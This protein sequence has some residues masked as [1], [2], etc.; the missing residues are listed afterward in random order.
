MALNIETC[1]FM[2]DFP[3]RLPIIHINDLKKI[4]K[5]EIDTLF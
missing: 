4:L 1:L 3:S 5:F 2:T